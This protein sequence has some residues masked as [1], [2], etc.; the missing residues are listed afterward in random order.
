MKTNN[1]SEIIIFLK[2]YFRVFKSK[3]GKKVWFWLG[4]FV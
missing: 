2:Q 1:L 4:F 3:K